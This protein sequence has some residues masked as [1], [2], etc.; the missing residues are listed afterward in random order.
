ML[1]IQR[2]ASGEAGEKRVELFDLVNLF[3]KFKVDEHFK[4]FDWERYYKSFDKKYW[5]EHCMSL[6]VV[7]NIAAVPA[8]KWPSI[9]QF[10]IQ[11]LDEIIQE[12]RFEVA[13][14]RK[15]LRQITEPFHVSMD[16]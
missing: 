7:L 13:R 8:S 16:Q 4:D 10:I 14:N 11:N 6:K 3:G 9:L 12:Y 15:I 1:K 2:D 5:N